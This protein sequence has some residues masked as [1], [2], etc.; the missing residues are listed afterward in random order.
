MKMIK[1][2]LEE[3]ADLLVI[4]SIDCMLKHYDKYGTWVVY[5]IV[6]DL[7]LDTR[8]IKNARKSKDDLHSHLV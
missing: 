8:G 7:N 2:S 4:E 6:G 3:I 1:E 5:D